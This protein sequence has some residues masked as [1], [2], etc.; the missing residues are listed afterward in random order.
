M[1]RKEFLQIC[2]STAVAPAGLSKAASE[3]QE[4]ALKNRSGLAWAP[5]H[6]SGGWAFGT[7]ALNG[8]AVD[9]PVEHG[10]LLLHNLHTG[11]ER[12]L[13]AAEVRQLDSR[14]ALASGTAAIDGATFRFEVRLALD[15]ALPAAAVTL[16]W[17]VDRDLTGWEICFAYCSAGMYEWR[18]TLYPFAGD[19]AEVRRD[20]LSYVG[21]PAALM[22]RDDR[23][24]ALLFAIDPSSDC[25]NPRTWTGATGFHFRDLTLA[26]QFRAC[27]GR[28]AAGVDYTLP[29]QLFVTDEPASATAVTQLVRAWIRFNRY[30][31][32]PLHVRTPDEAL[33]LYLEARRTTPMWQ[34]GKGYQ[35]EDAWKAVY[36]AEI[37][38]SAYFDY[39]VWEQTG[40][41]MWRE[42]A[43]Q[44]ADFLHKAQHLDPADPHFGVI[45]TNYELDTNR[46]T[47]RDH[48]PIVG[49]RVDMNAFA[50][51][52]LLML[53]QR[54]HEREGIDRQE[55]RQAAVRIADWLVKQQ[56]PDGGLPQYVDYRTGRKSISVVSGRALL[57]LPIIYRI[58]GEEKYH[59]LAED[60]ERFLRERVEARYWF[61][62]QH[63]DLWPKDYESDSVWCAVEYWLDQYER[64]R[65]EGALKRAEADAW[66]AFLMWC[67]KQL[68]WVRNP[69]QTCHA[70]QE[71]YLQYSNYCYNNRKIECLFRLGRLTGEHLFSELGERVMQCGFWAQQTEGPYYG[72]QHERMSDPWLG[73]SDDVNSTGELYFSELAL[74][75]N[76]QLLEMGKARAGRS[77]LTG[78]P[79]VR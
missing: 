52:Y 25:L 56:N 30:T 60:L 67:P 17:S 14:S 13:L 36:I 51:R 33:A 77:R 40:E 22:F 42:R 41:P 2:A 26:P 4:I 35:I 34:P 74:D 3:T 31:V 37:P 66:F 64:T 61:T 78:T 23:S 12:W 20:R 76:L 68:T 7:L 59:K 44:S 75:A 32:Q 57:A 71:H 53:W 45:E 69:T 16:R 10:M 1:T 65:D 8:S 27:A 48:T 46:F 58:T 70:E 9:N 24:L 15:E 62:G 63:P 72:A 6:A 54:V 5:A 43:F 18:C 50:A 73:V 21:V 55:W 19:S 11:E 28:I 39:L 29:L 47:S 49:Y 79:R 38:I